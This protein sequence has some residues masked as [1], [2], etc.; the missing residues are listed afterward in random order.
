ML[1]SISRLKTHFVAEVGKPLAY[2]NTRFGQSFAVLTCCRVLHGFQ[3]GAVRSKRS[4]VLW[5]AESLEAEWRELIDQAWAERKGAR[6]G[7]KIRQAAKVELLQET[8][9]FITYAQNV[10]R[11]HRPRTG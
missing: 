1:T 11:P 5:A 3:T 6:F 10:L 2:F 4:S 9:R 8:A 7:V